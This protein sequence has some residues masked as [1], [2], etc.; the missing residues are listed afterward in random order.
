MSCVRL[1][2]LGFFQLTLL[3]LL[4]ACDAIT[5]PR[6]CF[7]ALGVDLISAIHAFAK[8]AFADSVQ[9]SLHH[10]EKLALIVADRKE[11]FFGV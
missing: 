11:K 3:L 2:A 9:C 5:R 6:H 8:G 4:L 1:S 10:I 7:Q